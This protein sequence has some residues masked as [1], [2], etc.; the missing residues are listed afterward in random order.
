MPK[1]LEIKLT[2][3]QQEYIILGVVLVGG[4]IYVYLNI[5]LKPTTEKIKK[6][7]EDISATETKIENLKIQSAQLPRVEKEL[8]ALKI[9][10]EELEKLLP[11]E[12][13]LPSLIKTIM[14]LAKKRNIKVSYIAPSGESEQQ[15]FYEIPFTLN[16]QA[17]FHSFMSFLADLGSHSRIF[18]T[19]Q[20]SLNAVTSPTESAISVGGNVTIVTYKYRQQ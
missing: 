14:T 20:F 10:I 15:Y 12:T 16:F 13:K 5:L 8:Q 18:S 3:K 7:N 17:N 6:L 4:F 9:G 1:K 2:K 19:K 11:R